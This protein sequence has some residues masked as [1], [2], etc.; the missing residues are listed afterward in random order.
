MSDSATRRGGGTATRPGELPGSLDEPGAPGS[1]R[2]PRRL[3]GELIEFVYR[4]AGSTLATPRMALGVSLTGLVLVMLVGVLSPN[5]NTLPP[6]FTGD[7]NQ[8]KPLVLPLSGHLWELPWWVSFPM[9][10]LAIVLQCLGLSGLLWANS[11]GWRPNPRYLFLAACVIVGLIVNITPVGSSDAA[12]YAAY[13]HMANKGFDPYTNNPLILGPQNDYTKAVGPMWVQTPSVYG[14]IAT[15]VQ[16]LAAWFGGLNPSVTVHYLMIFNGVAFLG[17]G[18]FLLKT[19]ADPVRATLM[20]VANP[21][22]IQQLV[23]GGHLD[24]Y[25][26][27]ASVVGV[28][29]ARGGEGRWR[30][31]AAGVAVGVACSF[32][33]NAGLVGVAMAWALVMRRDWWNLARLSI[34]GVGSVVFFY[35]F[36][37]LH[38]FKQ[39]LT[40]SGL[41]ATPSPWRLFQ[42]SLQG[43]FGV[44]GLSDLGKTIG[45]VATSILWP[46]LMIMLAVVIYRRFSPDQPTM[47]TVPFALSF[48]WIVVAPWSLPWYT[49]LAWVILALLPRN[50]MTRWLTLATVYLAV[51]HSS[52]GGAVPWVTS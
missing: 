17:V 28:Q 33:L 27:A 15:W 16:Q 41:V 34:G 37:G 5:F 39:L 49:V 30:Y 52:G 11:R 38:A 51:M 20:W 3:L 14:P 10:Y 23:A 21:V 22:L 44:F 6:N 42:L 25:L 2:R 43:G 32:K 7:P 18:Y 35:S 40:A 29:I 31:F 9:T 26:A 1:A 13:G 12:S 47:V 8:L 46:T 24:T 48:A 45:A 50:P 36:Y 19:A 4:L